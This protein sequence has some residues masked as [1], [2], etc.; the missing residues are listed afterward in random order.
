MRYVGR[1]YMTY[2]YLNGMFGWGVGVGAME[3][4]GGGLQNMDVINIVE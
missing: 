1:V 2:S 3:P 4:V